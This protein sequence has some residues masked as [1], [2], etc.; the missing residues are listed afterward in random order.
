MDWDT[1]LWEQYLWLAKE[2]DGIVPM[3]PSDFERIVGRYEPVEVTLL[4]DEEEGIEMLWVI[5]KPKKED[6]PL[7]D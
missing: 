3:S 7:S 5:Y 6:N 4:Y 2:S 1:L